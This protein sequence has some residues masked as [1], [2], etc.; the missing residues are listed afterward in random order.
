[1][2]QG[3]SA[4][5]D[6]WHFRTSLPHVEPGDTFAATVSGF[7]DN[8][9]EPFVRLG[10]TVLH[11]PEGKPEHTHCLVEIR[12]RSFDRDTHRGTAELLE[13]LKQPTF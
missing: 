2:K 9:Q 3:L 11:I 8:R 6:G 4:F 7:D 10:D 13:V 5:F 1:M 12:V